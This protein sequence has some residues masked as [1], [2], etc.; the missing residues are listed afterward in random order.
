MTAENPQAP[1][2]NARAF[3]FFGNR[4]QTVLADHDDTEGRYDFVE[5]LA[6]A[7]SETPLHRHTR[8]SE[9]VY[10]L[11]GETTVW[12]EGR[13]AV[14][15]AGDSFLIPPG[16]AHVV[17]TTGD[18][19]ARALNVVSPSGFAHLFEEVGIPDTDGTPPPPGD[20]DME[21]F[22]RISAELGDELLGPPGTRP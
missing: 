5:A 6:P 13:T 14:L 20:F 22:G 9:H 3:W 21:L 11:E 1:E 7:G 18:G 15:E 2:Q 4:H 10:A 12:L 8:Y 17:G 19:P 16:V